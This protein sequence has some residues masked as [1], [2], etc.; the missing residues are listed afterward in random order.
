VGGIIKPDGT[1]ELQGETKGAPP[2]S[3]KVFLSGTDEGDYTAPKPMVDKRYGNVATTDLKA[4][5]K[6]EKN[7]IDFELDPPAK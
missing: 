1:Y 4:E 5:V 3:Y 2:G 6:A 7:K